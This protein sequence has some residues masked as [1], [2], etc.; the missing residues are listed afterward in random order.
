[1]YNRM[2]TE[3]YLCLICNQNKDE[4]FS[5]VNLL[6]MSRQDILFIFFSFCLNLLP[7]KNK[8]TH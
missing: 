6:L 1:M 2:L 5:N 7:I 4:K 8:S 3:K